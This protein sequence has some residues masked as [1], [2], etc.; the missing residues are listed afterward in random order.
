MPLFERAKGKFHYEIHQYEHA[1]SVREWTGSDQRLA[2]YCMFADVATASGELERLLRA[3][4]AEGF[5]PVDAAARALAASLKLEGPKPKV[6]PQLP[7][8][9]DVHVYNEA[10]GFAMGSLKLAGKGMEDG[11]RKWSKAVND[12]LLMPVSLYQDDSF[13]IRVVA[14]DA[15]NQQEKAEWVGRIVWRLNLADGKMC[16]S[17]GAEWLYPGYDRKEAYDDIFLRIVELPPGHYSATLYSYLSGVN[18]ESCL[19]QL[20]GGLGK[21]EPAGKWFRRT[22]PGESFPDWLVYWCVAHHDTD[23]GHEKEWENTPLPDSNSMPE[24]I[25]FLL[26]LE[27]TDAP[28]KPAKA[29]TV[30]GWF[31]HTQGAR[32]PERC[33]L[34]LVGKDVIGRAKKA[35][36][37]WFWPVEI[38]PRVEGSNASAVAGGA[39]AL[40]L[41]RLSDVYRLAKFCHRDVSPELRATLKSGERF[42]LDGKWPDEFLAI[43]V[44]DTLRFG[45]P[46][47]A[48]DLKILHFAS[49]RLKALPDGTQLEF[50]TAKLGQIP[51]KTDRPIGTHRYSG[52][53]RNGTWHID[54][55]FP[56]TS[57]ETLHAALELVA[58][59]RKREGFK[60][61]DDEEAQQILEWS[62]NNNGALLSDNLPIH[63]GGSIR[64]K[65]PNAADYNLLGSA[66]FAVRYGKVW[67]VFSFD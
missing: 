11:D 25:G 14:G 33:P 38:Y 19:D 44:D 60:V 12:G 10:T 37:K 57:A 50:V 3:K 4:S 24:F 54:Q 32:K 1:L 16:I 21:S 2:G 36:G 17:G 28:E 62:K 61:R 66:V 43:R 30:G 8:R 45:T 41:D 55:T 7:L 31:D 26:H 58:E 40:E 18:G 67:P 9:Q 6:A 52:T 39:V 27:P 64:L 23:R 56:E 22:R 34:G 53:V 49:A 65:D 35:E 47:V 48:N 63:E 5:L 29:E 42:A 13:A 59:T 15:L 51:P 20:A 46:P